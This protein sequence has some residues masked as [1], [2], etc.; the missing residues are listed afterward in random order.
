MKGKVKFYMFDYIEQILSELDSSL[1]SGSSVT[2]AAAHLFKVNDGA[3]KLSWRK[4]DAFHRNVA[5]LLFLSKRAR[6]N[7]QTAVAFLCTRV[8][9][10]DVDDNKKLGRVMRHLRET[11]FLPLVLGWD[12]IGN[13]YWRVDASFCGAQ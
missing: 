11:M 13:T 10:P 4:A 6:P 7:L 12:E 5:R 2:P 9:S 3:V 1:M 8:Q